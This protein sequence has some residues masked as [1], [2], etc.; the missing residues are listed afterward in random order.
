[1]GL[2]QN[3]VEYFNKPLGNTLSATVT[4]LPTDG[5][6]VYVRLWFGAGTGMYQ[7]RDFVYTLAP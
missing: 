6:R 3:G 7:Y 2:T 4:N 1:V 5:R